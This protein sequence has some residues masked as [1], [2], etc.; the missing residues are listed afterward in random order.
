MTSEEFAA[1]LERFSRGMDALQAELQKVAAERDALALRLQSHQETQQIV[2]P[3]RNGLRSE[4]YK[5]REENA[6]LR[7]Q[8]RGVRNPSY[9]RP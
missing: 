9:L 7:E 3:E 5:L 2:N 6:R 4:V 1:R 8:L